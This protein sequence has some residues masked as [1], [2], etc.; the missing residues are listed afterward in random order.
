MAEIRQVKPVQPICAVTFSKQVDLESVI[1][2]LKAIM[3]KVDERSETYSFNYT[4][5][6]TKEMGIGL[7][8]FFLS[9]LKLQMPDFLADMK[10]KT[11]AV[12]KTFAVK[13]KRRINLDPGYLTSAKVVIASA[14]DFAHRIYLGKGIYGD[15]QLQYRH[16][17]FWPEKW[18]FPDYT[19]QPVIEFFEKIRNQI[20]QKENI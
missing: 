12:E 2:A 11:N 3:G 7:R 16:G 5:Y 14:K 9:F 19:S 10:N 8:K 20:A 1:S 17:H 6:Y 18:T 4:D 13:G 15:L